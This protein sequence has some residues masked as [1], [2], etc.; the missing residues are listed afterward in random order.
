MAKSDLTELRAIPA[1]QAQKVPLI[2]LPLLRKHLH[3]RKDL[4]GRA[5]SWRTDSLM[6]EDRI[7]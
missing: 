5:K 7:V 4:V 6:Q 1:H 3:L 2:F